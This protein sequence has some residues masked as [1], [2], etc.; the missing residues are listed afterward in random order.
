MKEFSGQLAR[1]LP[2][3][4]RVVVHVRSPAARWISALAVLSLFSW[5]VVTFTRDRQHAE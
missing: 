2:A 4:E 3:R 1:R 5:V